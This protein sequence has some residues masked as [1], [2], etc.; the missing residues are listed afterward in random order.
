ML[1]FL[2]T[3]GQGAL[4]VGGNLMQ[5]QADGT[6]RLEVLSAWVPR[7]TRSPDGPVTVE[8]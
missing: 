2:L 3:P 6:V 1:G 5:R 4:R 7:L 8:E